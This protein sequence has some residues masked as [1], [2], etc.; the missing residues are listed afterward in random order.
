MQEIVKYVILKSAEISRA[1]SAAEVCFAIQLFTRILVPVSSISYFTGNVEKSFPKETDRQ[2]GDGV[3]TFDEFAD[4]VDDEMNLLP[5]YCYD[6]L[7]GGVVVDEAEYLHPARRA[8][9]LYILGTYTSDP[10]LGKQIRLYFGSFRACVADSPTAMK[11]Q[12]RKTLRHEFLHHL[13]TRARIFGKESLA[14]E[15]R[16]NM[17]RYFD[18]HKDSPSGK[19]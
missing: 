13:E 15:D 1:N 14:E 12:I 7:N 18:R 17:I 19:A 5:D 8:D 2:K 4:I 11:L 10:V 3:M 16:Q 9:D 6:E